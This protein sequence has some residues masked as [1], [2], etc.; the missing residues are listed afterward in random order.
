MKKTIEEYIDSFTAEVTI[1]GLLRKV[2]EDMREE[3]VDECVSIL[4][5]RGV[6]MGWKA[7]VNNDNSLADDD[8]QIPCDILMEVESLKS[9]E[10]K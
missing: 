8:G 10:I 4:K 5:H 9:I 3:I 1:R 6:T 7:D 2:A